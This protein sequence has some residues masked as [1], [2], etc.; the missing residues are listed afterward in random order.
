VTAAR[1]AWREPLV[2]LMLAI[3]A[4]TVIAGLFTLRI[5]S[6]GDGLDAAPEPVRRTLQAQ[7]V[8]LAPDRRAAALGLSA[9][10]QLDATGRPHVALAGAAGEARMQLHF[11]HATRSRDDRDWTLSDDDEWLGV[12]LP[13]GARGR[14]VLEDP[15]QGWRLVGAMRA[16][17]VVPLRP[18]VGG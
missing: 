3:P 13:A 6:A 16:D 11:V 17:G 2:W 8:D 15:A 10:L 4:A 1:P 9:R 18:A 7:V 14:W 5:A 12:P